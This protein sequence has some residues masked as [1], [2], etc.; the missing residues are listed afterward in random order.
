MATSG[1]EVELG[2]AIDLASFEAY[3]QKGVRPILDGLLESIDGSEWADLLESAFNGLTIMVALAQLE[4]LVHY[5]S[6]LGLAVNSHHEGVLSDV[7]LG[8]ALKGT[9]PSPH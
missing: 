4:P 5:A 8:L 1:A 2:R 6:E 7:L 9:Q 3:L